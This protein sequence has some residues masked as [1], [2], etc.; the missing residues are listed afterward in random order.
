MKFTSFFAGYIHKYVIY[1]NTGLNRYFWAKKKPN[2]CRVS[3]KTSM[4]QM[5]GVKPP[6]QPWQGRI[7]V[8]EPHLQVI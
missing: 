1:N 7:L 5:R 8:V 4:E 2:T 3:G 6:S